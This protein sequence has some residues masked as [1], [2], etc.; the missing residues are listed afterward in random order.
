MYLVFLFIST[1]VSCLGSHPDFRVPATYRQ[2]TTFSD[3]WNTS[4]P[5]IRMYQLT[6]EHPVLRITHIMCS[7]L[8]F[9]EL[10]LRFS[11]CPCKAKFFISF[12][13]LIDILAVLPMFTFC[14]LHLIIPNFWMYL[15]LTLAYYLVGLTTIFRSVRI[16]KMVKHNRGLQILCLALKASG[17]ELILLILLVAIGMLIFST[18]IYLVELSDPYTFPSIPTGFWWSIITMTTVGYGDVVPVTSFGCIV[19]VMCA[20]SG[21][22]ITG[23]PI[24]VI[25][26]NFHLYYTYAK[27]KAK[28]EQRKEARTP[29]LSHALMPSEALSSGQNQINEERSRKKLY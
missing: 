13:N 15:D 16:M 24:P 12:F 27:L 19:G 8:F 3:S 23:L 2:N 29:T 14:V 20:I 10:L 11:V 22:L 4:N 18:M 26:S 25:A 1:F 7:F 21:M 9:I 28:M 17:R 5:K 6:E